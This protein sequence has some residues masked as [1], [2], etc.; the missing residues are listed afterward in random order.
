MFKLN[1]GRLWWWLLTFII[2]IVSFFV[3]V[4]S[5][6]LARAAELFVDGNLGGN[7]SGNYSISLRN[8]SGSDG[9]AYTT[10][11][12]AVSA[13]SAGDTI[14]IR[15]G[16]YDTSS[17]I[18]L[19]FNSLSTTTIQGYQ[20]EAVTLTK[21]TVAGPLLNLGS[22]ARNILIQR[23][24]FV[25]T[26]YRVI[27]GWTNYS[28]NVWQAS[29]TDA[30]TQVRFNTTNGSEV[31]SIGEVNSANEWFYSSGTM[32]AYSTSDPDT[33]YT[34]PGINV[35][36]NFDALAIG[37]PSNSAAGNLISIDNCNFQDF[38]HAAVKGTWRWHITDSTFVNM[39]TDEN[40]HDVYANGVQTSGNEMIFEYNYFGY[41]PGAAL[42]LYPGPEYAIA[43]YNVFNG[44]FG[45]TRGGWGVL[46]SGAYSKVYNND[47]YGYGS[48]GALMFYQDNSHD[49]TVNNNI[50]YN[51]TYDL[52]IDSGGGLYYP[53]NN[54]TNKN[55]FGST[56]KCNGCVDNTGIGGPDYTP[57]VA[58]PPNI[59]DTYNPFDLDIYSEALDFKI[60]AVV[61]AELINSGVDLGTDSQLGWD[62]N[63]T[64]WPISTINQ[65]LYGSGWDVGAFVY[66]E[67]L[68]PT[69]TPT[70]TSSSNF[71]MPAAPECHDASPGKITPYLYGA[72]AQDSRSII[73]YFTAAGDPVDKYILQ[74]G[75]KA[76]I[77][78]WG[79][80][81][82]GGS[83]IR[84]YLVRFLAPITT[85]Y[86]RIRAGNGCSVGE[87][88]NVISA[89]TKSS[90]SSNFVETPTSSTGCTKYTVKRGNSLWLIA[91]KLLGKGSL[92]NKIIEQNL[93]KYPS[94]RSSNIILS[95]W[96]LE[97]NCPN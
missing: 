79:S 32:Y 58:E 69:P 63:A 54:T 82:I 16:S 55:Y 3:S 35:T 47:F 10:L 34:S 57:L 14:S 74:F 81:N 31:G 7:C 72:I 27:S 60:D 75:K 94:M 20:D 73:L 45:T 29:W 49:N 11:G 5:P 12:S 77:F 78:T 44:L 2:L 90:G 53:T 22:S 62:S 84:T 46:L 17:S 66:N 15:Q 92:Y 96:D 50:F 43:R 97:I 28:G 67:G 95:G 8:C 56:N 9:S 87:W 59:L 48:L 65:N 13:A 33:A 40:D 76:G 21:S 51:N 39:G 64:T 24:D 30:T 68:A 61:A 71:S 88:S 4:I 86:F 91:K 80:P 41:T 42:H 25:G 26:L 6:K 93:K 37:N 36:D 70:P 19:N 1:H 83:S 23:L 85:Y 52:E 89:R 38:S 18:T